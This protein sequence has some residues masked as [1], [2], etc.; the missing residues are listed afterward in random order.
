M[1]RDVETILGL[2]GITDET[3]SYD[4]LLTK[5]KTT[6]TLTDD[7]LNN[8]MNISVKPLPNVVRNQPD[9]VKQKMYGIVTDENLGLTAVLNKRFVLFQCLIEALKNNIDLNAEQVEVS[10]K[11]LEEYLLEE[12]DSY[13]AALQNALSQLESKININMTNLENRLNA[14]IEESSNELFDQINALDTK[15]TNLNTTL[16]LY[17]KLTDLDNY[18]TRATYNQFVSQV[19]SHVNTSNAYFTGSTPIPKATADQNGKVIHTTYAT[20]ESLN[21]AISDINSIKKILT[22]DDTDLDTLQELVNALKNNVSRISDIF[23]QLNLKVNKED[24]YLKPEIDELLKNTSGASTKFALTNNLITNINGYW[25]G[26]GLYAFKEI[27]YG[28]YYVKQLQVNETGEVVLDTEIIAS[29]MEAMTG[30]ATYRELMI[31]L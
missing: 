2:L 29:Y 14:N 7:E 27:K 20:L 10:L 9:M 18:V 19:T 25:F 21:A 11:D 3:I 4:T 1:A 5:L 16:S 23:Y 15:I 26:G 12:I 6:N 30:N 28:D 22:S 31:T 24:V 8:I 17:A 13:N